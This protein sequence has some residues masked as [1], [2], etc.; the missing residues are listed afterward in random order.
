M[1]IDLSEQIIQ[2]MKKCRVCTIATVSSECQPSASAVFFRN[3]GVDIYFNTGRDTQ[4]VRGIS[5]NPNVAIVMQ[6]AGIAPIADRD[7]K[8]ISVP[9]KGRDI[10]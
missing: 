9:R 10:A 3:L 4:K 7:I 8:G 2:F 6:E 1:S 5:A